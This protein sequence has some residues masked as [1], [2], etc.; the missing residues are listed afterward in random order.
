MRLTIRTNQALRVLMICAVNPGKLLR[1]AD[2]AQASHAS[3]H[4]LA[5][6]V[7]RLA[8]LGFLDSVRGR[9]GGVRLARAPSKINIG[10]VVKAIESDFPFAECFEPDTC[11]CPI[12]DVCMLKG[13]FSKALDAFYAVLSDV[14]LDQLVDGNAPLSERLQVLEPA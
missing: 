5:Q 9:A 3:E 1:S 14:T 4:H 6:I 8:K 13:H 10:Q 7:H 12:A 11:T 2:I